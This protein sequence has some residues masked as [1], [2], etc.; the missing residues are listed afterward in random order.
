MGSGDRA[1]R[2]DWLPAGRMPPQSGGRADDRLAAHRRCDLFDD[3][4]GIEPARR[5]R[6]H[7]DHPRGGDGIAMLRNA[8]HSRSALAGTS[9]H[10]R[11]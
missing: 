3:R 10:K 8:G 4:G 2:R 6:S 5:A 1:A 11:C 9:S 7:R